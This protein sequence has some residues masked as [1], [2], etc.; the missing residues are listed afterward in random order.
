MCDEAV[1]IESYSLVYFPDR[2][3]TEE[4]C[5]EAVRRGSYP[6]A[7]VP[8]HLETQE[9][10]DEVMHNNPEAFFLIHDRLK[11]QK[12]CIK[13]LE[14][15]P[16]QLED[17]S[18]RFKTQEMCGKA[19]WDGISSLLCVPDWFVT[20]QQIKIWL[21]HDEYCND[22]EA[23]E[24]YVDYQKRK[25]QKASIKEELLPIAWHP[26]RYWDWCMSEDEKGWWK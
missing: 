25:A 9:M 15:D 19:V 7:Y 1:R 18:D 6:L 5:N 12:M 24:W 21:D 14:V 13:P 8:D 10:C 20:H 22:D 17:V 2:F 16:W 26:S 23:I 3:K 11:T 4:M